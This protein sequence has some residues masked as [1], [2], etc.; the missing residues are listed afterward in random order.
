MQKLIRH[1]AGFV[2]DDGRENLNGMRFLDW[3]T[4]ANPLAIHEGLQAV[5]VLAMQSGSR[6][7][8]ALGDPDTEKLCEDTIAK[9]RK[10][11]PEAS[12]RKSPAALLALAGIRDAR[13]VDAMLKSTGPPTFPLFTGSMFSRRW[14]RPAMPIPL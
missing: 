7:M 8:K 9:L 14:P 12:G 2:G 6:L 11:M 1:L 10:H 3:P 5:M 4:S 13:D